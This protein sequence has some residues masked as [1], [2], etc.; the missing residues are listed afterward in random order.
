MK[1]YGLLVLRGLHHS[2]QHSLDLHQPP[3]FGTCQQNILP[4]V[5]HDAHKL[6]LSVCLPNMRAPQ[7]RSIHPLLPSSSAA[8]SVGFVPLL[9]IGVAL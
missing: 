6:Q 7:H 5:Y 3:P 9:G 2:P 4:W 8:V 1:Y